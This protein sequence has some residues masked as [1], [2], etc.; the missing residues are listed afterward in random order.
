MRIYSIYLISLLVAGAVACKKK[1]E[2]SPAPATPVNTGTVP[3]QPLVMS[4][5]T[6]VT[7]TDG[8]VYK[9][10]HKQV[11]SVNQ[12][13]FV[14]KRDKNGKLV[15]RV[16]HS[17]TATDERA[18]LISLDEQQHPGVFYEEGSGSGRIHRRISER[19]RPGQRCPPG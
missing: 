3:P 16:V 9:V 13:C 12:D 7:D 8:N 14:E 2:V 5:K 11:S 17:A 15:W 6:T 19:F 1:D 4:N 10:G 18:E